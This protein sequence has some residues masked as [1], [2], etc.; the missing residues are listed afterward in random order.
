[1]LSLF[2]PRKVFA[3]DIGDHCIKWAEL[4]FERKTPVLK[5]FAFLPIPDECREEQL[6]NISR[7]QLPLRRFVEKH[8]KGPVRKIRLC[9]S[10]KATIIKKVEIPQSEKK[11]MDELVYMEAKETIPFDLDEVNYSYQVI[12]SLPTVDK[13]KVNV[14][15]V[16]ARKNMIFNYE[17]LIKTSG[18][19]CECIDIGGFA[20][21][22]CMKF[23]SPP[24]GKNILVLDIGKSATEFCVF[25][26]GELVFSRILAGGGDFFSTALM[27]EM[28]V[29][30]KEAEA[31]KVSGFC[32]EKGTPEEVHKILGE[33][34]KYFCDDL[35][36]GFEYF[37]NQFPGQ[38]IHKCYVTG[39]GSQVKNLV[40]EISSSL[41]LP[42]EVL[43]PFQKLKKEGSSPGDFVKYLLPPVVGM[44]LR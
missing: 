14:L 7:M 5:N 8:T 25:N 26:S 38:K 28:G 27:K 21:S 15:L 22:Y 44:C 1:M 2:G 10:G 37:Y 39:G 41:Q 32:D 23:L 19:K 35:A 42:T 20:L 29:D 34:V 36:V 13:S 33:H 3:M 9:V 11:L 18:F 16:A 17:Q 24:A 43:D 6:F 40:E 12:N 4:V 30:E 31:L